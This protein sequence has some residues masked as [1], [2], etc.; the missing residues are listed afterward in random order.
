MSSV[1]DVD[2]IIKREFPEGLEAHRKVGWMGSET[3]AFIGFN[4]N[5]FAYTNL[6][7]AECHAMRDLMR[8][9]VGHSY[10]MP[11]DPHVVTHPA[12]DGEAEYYEVYTN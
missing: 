3:G 10:G 11:F 8:G 4:L 9:T 12:K 7:A 6:L 2:E 1:E 5:R